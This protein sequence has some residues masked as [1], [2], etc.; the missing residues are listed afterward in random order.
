VI[1]NPHVYIVTPETS[2]DAINDQ[3]LDHLVIEIVN[4]NVANN[5]RVEVQILSYDE[6][7]NDT[8]YGG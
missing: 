4:I 2:N 7:Y 3:L 8:I 1:S 6:L 5:E